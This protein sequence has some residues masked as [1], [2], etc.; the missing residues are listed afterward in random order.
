[1]I[2][3]FMVVLCVGKSTV[4]SKHDEVKMHLM[5]QHH[6]FLTLCKFHLCEIYIYIEGGGWLGGDLPV[7]VMLG[8]KLGPYT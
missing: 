5:Y 2:L 8:T 4:S 3:D 6:S 7:C 1:M